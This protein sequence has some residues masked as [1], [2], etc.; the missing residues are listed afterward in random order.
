MMVMMVPRA[1]EM[2]NGVDLMI[3][4]STISNIYSTR[5]V[6]SFGN[7]VYVLL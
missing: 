4:L 1:R 2:V 5:L 7:W 3:S 6:D